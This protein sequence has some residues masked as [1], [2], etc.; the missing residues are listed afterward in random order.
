MTW[1]TWIEDDRLA[2][3]LAGV[4]RQING[5]IAG[6][7]IALAQLAQRLVGGQRKTFGAEEAQRQLLC[8]QQLDAS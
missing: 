2:Q 4:H 6:A 8:Q 3:Q 7:E 5:H 1:V